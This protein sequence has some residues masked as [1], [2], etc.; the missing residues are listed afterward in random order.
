MARVLWNIPVLIMPP[1][2]MGAMD[3]TKAFKGKPVVRL[4]FLTALSTVAVILGAA[5]STMFSNP[6]F[7]PILFSLSRLTSSLPAPRTAF[8]LAAI[9]YPVLID[10]V[11]FCWCLQSDGM[12]KS[13]ASGL[14][15]AQA[16]YPQQVGRV[17]R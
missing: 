9:V 14:Y 6:I 12:T 5:P 15:P 16:V 8:Y 2:V 3:K 13:P 10:F 11:L 1:V 17:L 4:G 7:F